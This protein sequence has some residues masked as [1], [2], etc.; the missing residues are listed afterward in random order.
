VPAALHCEHGAG[1]IFEVAALDPLGSPLLKEIAIHVRIQHSARGALWEG[2]RESDRGPESG[3]AVLN[4]V[5]KPEVRAIGKQIQERLWQGE[6]CSP[7]RDK[8]VLAMRSKRF[9]KSRNNA[10]R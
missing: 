3:E 9:D 5:D 2:C 4:L 10:L 8:S 6:A 7:A 1:N